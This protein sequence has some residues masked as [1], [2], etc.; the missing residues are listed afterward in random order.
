[1]VWIFIEVLDNP[2]SAGFY[3]TGFPSQIPLTGNA[4]VSENAS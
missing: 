4:V 1:M 2:P 3:G